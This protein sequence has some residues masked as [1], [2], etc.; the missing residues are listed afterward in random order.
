[1]CRLEKQRIESIQ[2]VSSVLPAEDS[3]R[4]IHSNPFNV[5]LIE[6][7]GLQGA[8]CSGVSKNSILEIRNPEVRA[9]RG[10]LRSTYM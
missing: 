5:L 9:P 6:E 10:V 3:I 2:R 7:E 8:P 1:M 4:M